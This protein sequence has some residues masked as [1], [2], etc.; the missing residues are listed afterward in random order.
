MLHL[1]MGLVNLHL[2][3]LNQNTLSYLF[4]I[5]L[6]F[7]SLILLYYITERPFKSKK[8]LLNKN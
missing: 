4:L 8:F 2:K 3:S 6:N 5:P 7:L 1:F